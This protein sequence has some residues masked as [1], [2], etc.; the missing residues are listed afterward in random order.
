[1]VEVNDHEYGRVYRRVE[2]ELQG[3]LAW[4]V[5]FDAS[6]QGF[7]A[8]TQLVI[9][10]GDDVLAF[11]VLTSTWEQYQLHADK[12][13]ALFATIEFMHAT[14]VPRPPP[15]FEGLGFVETTTRSPDG[16]WTATAVVA[17]PN[18]SNIGRYYRGLKVAQTRGQTLWQPLD[19]W[20]RFGFGYL[21]PGVI[22]WSNDGH[23]LYFTG[24]PHPDGCAPAANGWDLQR[25]DLSNGSVTEILASRARWL[26]LS[27]GDKWLAYLTYQPIELVLHEMTTGR[28]R[29]IAIASDP[30]H[31]E[32][33]P[34]VWSPNSRALAFTLAP[35]GCRPHGFSLPFCRNP[36][37][38]QSAPNLSL[39]KY[40]SENR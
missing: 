4:Q 24:V 13:E 33:A 29:R 23:Y 26:A 10:N 34:R 39:T 12:I 17:T 27:P 35:W 37:M 5:D 20:E 38:G 31:T 16:Q 6:A 40:L 15:R 28:E 8:G 7:L 21:S 11:L 36:A 25:L 14:P 1:M 30:A 3:R 9:Q 18:Q 2:R 32:A 19:V 22:K